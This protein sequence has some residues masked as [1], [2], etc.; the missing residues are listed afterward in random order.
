MGTRNVSCF[1]VWSEACS[2]TLHF[3]EAVLAGVAL[4]LAI[5]ALK[6]SLKI[7]K[8]EDAEETRN[9]ARDR[10]AVV[11][12]AR[13]AADLP[14]GF[15]LD[16]PGEA[17]VMATN[18]EA[19]AEQMHEARKTLYTVARGLRLGTDVADIDAVRTRLDERRA[20]A[21]QIELD[22]RVL[23]ERARNRAKALEDERASGTAPQSLSES[24]TF[25]PIKESE[26]GLRRRDAA[27]W[28]DARTGDYRRFYHQRVVKEVNAWFDENELDE[29]WRSL[30]AAKL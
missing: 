29:D 5:W 9:W 1:E 7:R 28:V 3:L 20:D 13:I 27:V 12:E 6:V 2:G 8:K 23:A 10:L 21:L 17:A 14:D 30:Q 19:V 11:A 22:C 24:K 25:V 4:V 15:R 16:S 26:A 18:Y